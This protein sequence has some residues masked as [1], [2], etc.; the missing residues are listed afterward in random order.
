MALRHSHIYAHIQI[1]VR[2][3]LL[4]EPLQIKEPLSQMNKKVGHSV[5][6]ALTWKP[7]KN[8]KGLPEKTN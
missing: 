8:E 4:K 6:N 5:N 3:C 1:Y 7:A 2:I